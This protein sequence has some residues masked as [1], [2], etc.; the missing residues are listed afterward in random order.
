MRNHELWHE[1]CGLILN[2]IQSD[3][4][5]PYGELW[6][7]GG[8]HFATIDISTKA[9]TPSKAAVSDEWNDSKT[10]Y[11]P[12]VGIDPQCLYGQFRPRF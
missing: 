10:H 9:K 12:G 4:E 1:L 3:A 5:G 8:W 7:S 2:K 11:D 6:G